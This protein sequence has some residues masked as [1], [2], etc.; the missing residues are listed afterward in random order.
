MDFCKNCKS[1]LPQNLVIL[2]CPECGIT[3]TN[4]EKSIRQDKQNSKMISIKTQILFAILSF[5]LPFLLFVTS[6]RIHKLK[7]TLLLYTILSLG[8]F[9]FLIFVNT[10]LIKIFNP[11]ANIDQFPFHILFI[12]VCIIPSS[13]MIYFIT[14][15]TKSFN[16]KISFLESL[17]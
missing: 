11:Y 12:S 16:A 4:L 5:I 13:F 7:K 3:L 15:W 17:K 8:S 14:K 9:I 6:Y 2:Y 10:I 1:L